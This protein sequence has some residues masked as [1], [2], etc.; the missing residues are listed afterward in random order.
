MVVRQK[1]Q[2]SESNEIFPKEKKKA[3]PKRRTSVTVAVPSMLQFSKMPAGTEQWIAK[4]RLQFG[5]TDD[6][7]K[8]MTFRKIDR[9]RPNEKHLPLK[10]TIG[11]VP[12]D[13]NC[14]LRVLSR[15]IFGTQTAYKVLREQIV[16]YLE[17]HIH[18]FAF[19]PANPDPVDYLKRIGRDKIHVGDLEV[20]AAS[21]LFGVKNFDE[22]TTGKQTEF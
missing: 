11:E 17:N 2:W 1:G 21:R 22:A 4:N 6:W 3:V 16:I 20:E 10:C 9:R 18:L 14:C 13:G 5:V 7:E 8:A 15:M 12:G 19:L